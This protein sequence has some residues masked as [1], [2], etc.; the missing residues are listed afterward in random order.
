MGI[1]D[2]FGCSFFLVSME[3]S[4]ID[5]TSRL[6]DDVILGEVTVFNFFGHLSH[7]KFSFFFQLIE[8][9]VISFYRFESFRKLTLI[10][11][12]VCF[13]NMIEDSLIFVSDMIDWFHFF[14]FHIQ[15]MCYS[16][17]KKTYPFFQNAYIQIYYPQLLCPN[18]RIF[19]V[20]LPICRNS[21]YLFL[22]LL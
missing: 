15:A 16:P 2:V 3:L 19:H 14:V 5:N 21:L 4:I 8:N 13:C 6:L 20:L 7:D 12:C 22:V 1:R 17:L 18:L 11:Q 9:D 10:S